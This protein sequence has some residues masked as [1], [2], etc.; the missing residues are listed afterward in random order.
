MGQARKRRQ[1]RLETVIENQQFQNSSLGVIDKLPDSLS[2]SENILSTSV[3]ENRLTTS[4]NIPSTT[5][6]ILTASENSTTTSE[7]RLSTSASEN[8]LTISDNIL[9]T[10]KNIVSPNVSRE[11]R[12]VSGEEI[13]HKLGPGN[14][15][16][17]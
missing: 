15:Y 8:R 14:V 4:E 1:E 12:F 7:N 2:T 5:E 6:N 9:S 13:E 3:S 16:I 17:G 11:N 10:S